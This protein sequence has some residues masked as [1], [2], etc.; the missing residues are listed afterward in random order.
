M[1]EIL[2]N[3]EKIQ[4][5]ILSFIE[6][7]T[8]S[9]DDFQEFNDLDLPNKD[10][11]TEEIL[12]LINGISVNHHRTPTFYPKIF[13]I[14]IQFK[15]Q[16]KN[17]YSTRDILKIFKDKNIL[18]FLLKEGIL[19]KENVDDKIFIENIEKYS[20]FN[21]NE[22]PICEIIRKDSINEFISYIEQENIDLSSKIE[23]S[24]FETN[25]FLIKNKPSLIE[26]SAFFG[27]INIFKYLIGKEKEISGSIW[28]YAIHGHNFEI[29]KLLEANNIKPKKDNYRNCLIESIKCHHIE[30]SYYLHK[31]YN[32]KQSEN[33]NIDDYDDYDD[34]E[35]D[36]NK[37]DLISVSL[38][39]RNYCF[40]GKQ[41]ITKIESIYYL[42]KYNYSL[43]VENYDIKKDDYI[44]IN[45]ATIS[46]F[47]FLNTVFKFSMIYIIQK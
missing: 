3:L 25:Q 44:Y 35:E 33:E 4:L 11:Y 40:C 18:L 22:G 2:K 37:M 9:D 31:K 16:I 7:E 42:C 46:I 8:S 43:L 20:N 41:I 47:Y 12:Y 28:I 6:K 10:Q 19:T 15:D 27:S 30:M 13:K 29:I 5:N 34:E 14:L 36:F 23:T 26:Y 32:C 38:K 45:A 1:D 39:S 17:N 21:E 24:E